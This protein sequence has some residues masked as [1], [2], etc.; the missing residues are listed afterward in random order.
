MNPKGSLTVTGTSF[1]GMVLGTHSQ[2]Q[3]PGQLQGPA[4]PGD[5]P[6]LNRGQRVGPGPTDP[7]LKPSRLGGPQI[8]FPPLWALNPYRGCTGSLTPTPG[9]LFSEATCQGRA[10]T[11]CSLENPCGLLQ[12]EASH[13]T[14]GNHDT[15]LPGKD[16]QSRPLAKRSGMASDSS[17]DVHSWSA[18]ILRTNEKNSLPNTKSESRRM[19]LGCS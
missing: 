14:S 19:P 8:A 4:G 3:L 7:R 11:P 18:H 13:L 1:P 6:Q 12:P 15:C 17:R 16:A 9:C 10:Q 2:P 5:L